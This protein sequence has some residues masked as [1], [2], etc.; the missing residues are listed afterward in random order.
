[1][2]TEAAI[3]GKVDQLRGL[4]E[5]VIIGK[6][7]PAGSGYGEQVTALSLL[8]EATLA[9]MTAGDGTGAVATL[10]PASEAEMRELM[11]S[12]LVPVSFD[13]DGSGDAADADADDE[14]LVGLAVG[15]DGEEDAGTGFGFETIDEG[16]A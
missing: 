10:E 7:I 4:K 13:G 1:M 15:D 8:D 14:A 6:L 16:G 9:G 12:G 5:N 2:L 11:D 3:N